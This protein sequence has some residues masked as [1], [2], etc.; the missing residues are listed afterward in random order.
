[1]ERPHTD[2]TSNYGVNNLT[3]VT[4]IQFYADVCNYLF[5]NLIIIT[6][7]IIVSN[8]IAM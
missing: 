5:T 4:R 8:I 3:N 6:Q 7:E 2:V 1:M